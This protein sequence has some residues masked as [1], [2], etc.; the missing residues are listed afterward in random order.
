MPVVFA[1]RSGE[2]MEC[3]V[4]LSTMK[5]TT[6]DPHATISSA[7]IVR[8]AKVTTPPLTIVSTS[9]SIAPTP[10][11]SIQP[12][13]AMACNEDEENRSQNFSMNQTEANEYDDEEFPPSPKRVRNGGSSSQE[14]VVAGTPPSK[15]TRRL[16]QW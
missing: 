9:S 13:V 15:S 6:Y 3:E 10:A 7:P 1:V 5:D 16:F 14:E 12:S 4:V 8:A 11:M 2:F